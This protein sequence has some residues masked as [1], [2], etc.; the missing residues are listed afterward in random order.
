VR[1]I[2]TAPPAAD[3][4]ASEDPPVNG[5]GAGAGGMLVEEDSSALDR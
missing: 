3:A 5:L 2:E 4:I 1:K